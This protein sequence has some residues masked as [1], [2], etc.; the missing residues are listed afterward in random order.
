MLTV[1]RLPLGMMGG[2]IWMVIAPVVSDTVCVT[3]NCCSCQ[4]LL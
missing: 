1:C 3:T 4:T 2:A